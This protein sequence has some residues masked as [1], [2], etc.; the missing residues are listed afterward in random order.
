MHVDES[1]PMNLPIVHKIPSGEL[2][3]KITNFKK[4]IAS[5][6]S[7][8]TVGTAVSKVL[9]KVRYPAFHAQ[10]V[11]EQYDT[12]ELFEGM[13][14]SAELAKFY[15]LLALD[16]EARVILSIVPEIRMS[17][18]NVNICYE[19]TSGCKK[20]SIV[21]PLHQPEVSC[22]NAE[23]ARLQAENRVLR[24]RLENAERAMDDMKANLPSN[25]NGHSLG[26]RIF[27]E[28]LLDIESS[29][30]SVSWRALCASEDDTMWDALLFHGFANRVGKCILTECRGWTSPLSS[31]GFESM[32]QLRFDR[33]SALMKC[34]TDTTVRYN[35]KKSIV[36]QIDEL[37]V[38]GVKYDSNTRALWL[39]LHDCAVKHGFN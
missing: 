38:S 22:K 12:G 19:I 21:L 31:S 10:F 23:V 7:F 18:K 33:L 37:V 39:Q 9:D 30:F 36:Q 24:R 3:I 17:D 32:N 15:P 14:S 35:D 8:A 20:Y 5:G 34:M 27:L 6:W 4:E 1:A 29:S 13:F 2:A 28:K 16:D 11:F 26:M 25:E